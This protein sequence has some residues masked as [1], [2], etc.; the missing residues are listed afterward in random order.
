MRL[1]TIGTAQVSGLCI[2]GNPFSGFSHQGPERNKE[3]LDYHTPER[4]HEVLQNAEQ[5]G[6][7]TVF[8]RTDDNIF[9]VLKDYWNSGGR[10]Q[11]F[12]QVCIERGDPT[13]GAN[14][15]TAPSNWV[16]P[17]PIF[18]AKKNRS[19]SPAIAAWR[20]SAL[21]SVISTSKPARAKTWAIP[22]PI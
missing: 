21:M 18:T 19:T 15:S 10:I 8:A 1:R 6:I 17:G 22:F 5:N 9:G 7:S 4:I 11:W 12:A 3:M 16:A 13:P 20:A 14:G 2:G